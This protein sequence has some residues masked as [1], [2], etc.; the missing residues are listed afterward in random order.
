MGHITVSATIAAPVELV[1]GYV[2]DHKNTTKYMKDL[3]K[4]EPVGSQVHGKGSQFA[5][6]MKAGPLTL[7]S[8]V[9]ITEWAENQTIGWVSR[10]GLKQTGKW[11]F[12]PAGSGKTAATFDLEYEL[13]GGIAGRVAG[14]VAEPIMRGNIERSVQDLKAQTEKLVGKSAKASK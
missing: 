8:S 5:V 4:W 7:D 2:D 9:E 3:V 10:K 14:K 12:K 1:F 11:S 13:P 6:A